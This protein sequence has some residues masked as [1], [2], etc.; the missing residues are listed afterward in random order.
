MHLLNLLRN[1]LRN[2]GLEGTYLTQG[3]V[4]RGSP[5][6]CLHLPVLAEVV[7]HS[8][9]EANGTCLLLP[10]RC[11]PERLAESVPPTSGV[12]Q[13]TVI[14]VVRESGTELV[15]CCCTTVPDIFPVA[16]HCL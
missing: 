8:L 15:R 3:A 14:V 10:S 7:G 1:L 5:R 4:G 12:W 6:M 11:E 13:S 16:C 2:I 9:V